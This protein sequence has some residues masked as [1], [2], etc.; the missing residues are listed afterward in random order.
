MSEEHQELIKRIIESL[1][2]IKIDYIYREYPY[3]IEGSKTVYY[4]D[5]L[6]QIGSTIYIFECKT[7]GKEN[8]AKK[9]LEFHKWALENDKT[10]FYWTKN[11]RLFPFSS[12]KCLYISGEKNEIKNIESGYTEILDPNFLNNPLLLLNK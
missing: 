7:K 1:R 3:K 12:V 8:K 9:Q 11:R 10:Y 6:V 5:L 2:K 4:M